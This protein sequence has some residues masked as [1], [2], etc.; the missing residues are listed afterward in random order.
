M[1][2]NST[3]TRELNGFVNRLNAGL[4]AGTEAVKNTTNAASNAMSNMGSNIV[5]TANTAV[6][7]MNGIPP[8][9]TTGNSA[10]TSTI[11]SYFNSFGNNTNRG[12]NNINRGLNNINRG[13]NTLNMGPTSTLFVSKET[14]AWAYPLLVFI[15]LVCIFS[16]IFYVYND[17]LGKSY[18]NI[19]NKIKL[20]FGYDTPATPQPNLDTD[21][22]TGI[23]EKILPVSNKEV[24]NVSSNDYTYYDAEPLCRALGAELATYDQV[25]TAWENGADWCNYGWVKGQVAVYPTQRESWEKLQGGPDEEKEACGIPGINGGFFDNPE[26]KFGVTCYG[27]KP[28]QS[29][30]DQ[31]ILMQNGVIP[32]TTEMLK[33]DERVQDFK[34]QLGTI[35]LLPFNNKNWQET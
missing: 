8:T 26:M 6:N 28:A 15:I 32:R 7:A 21:Q 12:L 29:A 33:V 18:T 22:N 17:E 25:K 35:G 1:F 5:K 30:N 19:L 13:S 4:N 3:I 31:R 14:P 2:G 9:I 10:V 16:G 34:N 27:D 23:I 20:A 24:F 11:N